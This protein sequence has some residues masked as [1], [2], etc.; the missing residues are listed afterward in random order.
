M[1]LWSQL[2]EDVFLEA[3]ELP[4]KER[5]SFVDERCG[6]NDD[7]RQ[8]V[9]KLLNDYARSER[10]NFILE[11]PDTHRGELANDS[12]FVPS[13]LVGE[14]IDRYR[15]LKQIGEGGMGVVYMA[16]QIDDIKRRVAMKIIKLGM[17]T[18][19]V[20]ARFEAERQAMAMFDHPNITRVFDAGNTQTGRPYFV[21]ELVNGVEITRYAKEES[22]PL[23]ARLKLFVDVCDAIQH[24]HHKGIIHRDLKPSN[25]L[26]SEIDGK[27]IPKVI[28]F[29]IAK[30]VGF[31]LT[32]KTLFTR[33]SAIMGTPQY[34]SPEQ[35]KYDGVDVDTRSDVYS[36][37]VLL[38]ELITDTTP[39]SA[40]RLTSVSPLALYETASRHAYRSTF[41]ANRQHDP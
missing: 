14:T 41:N 30:A 9:M 21:M 26:V 33:H 40:E 23:E 34:M 36:L 31:N 20:I 12:S 38:Y 32:D 3:V 10:E 8:S 35:A 18:K 11:R 29:G 27:A 4:A 19:Q 15:L 6:D 24:A 13:E 25:V 7:A 39:L 16:E 5:S 17:D 2:V 22:L 28:D 37:G 1:S